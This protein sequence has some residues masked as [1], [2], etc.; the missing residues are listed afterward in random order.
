MKHSAASI[1]CALLALDGEGL[2]GAV[3]KGSGGPA[4][5]NFIAAFREMQRERKLFRLPPHVGADRLTG[6]I[7]IAAT[8][9]SGKPSYDK[10][11]IAEADGGVLLLTSAE[12]LEP[13]KAAI[14]ASAMDHGTSRFTLIACDEGIEDEHCPVILTERLAFHIVLKDED[15]VVPM[16]LAPARRLLPRVSVP[17]SVA[18]GLCQTALALLHC[19]DKTDVDD[20]GAAHDWAAGD[21]RERR[22]ASLRRRC[23]RAGSASQSLDQTR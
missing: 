17:D 15:E 9:K 20:F 8:L 7:D 18:E 13:G 14:L 5:E 23:S 1:A 4:Q 11:L 22:M 10:G 6:S 12:R 2:K 19:L 21:G 16:D 3:L